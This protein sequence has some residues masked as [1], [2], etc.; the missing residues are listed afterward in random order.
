MASFD[1][2]LRNLGPGL[3]AAGTGAL[4]QREAA[5][6]SS[7]RAGELGAAAAPYSQAAQQQLQ[8]GLTR[9]PQQMAQERFTQQQALLAPGYQQQEQD[10]LRRLQATGQGGIASFGAVAGTQQTPGQAINPQ[11]AALYAA[12]AGEKAKSAYGAQAEADTQIEN[13]LRRSGMLQ[14]GAAAAQGARRAAQPQYERPSTMS[15]I[16]GGASS[17][18]QNKDALGS[19]IGLF[20]GGASANPFADYFGGARRWEDLGWGSNY[21]GL[22]F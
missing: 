12:Q 20:G 11:L 1:E 21:S 17:L 19:I 8:M 4:Q 5:R 2:L 7:R 22:G 14:Q 9:D 15:Q 18:L 16:L 6:A 10:L 13:L 3:F